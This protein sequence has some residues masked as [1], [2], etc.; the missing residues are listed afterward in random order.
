MECDDLY[1]WI[2]KRPYMQN[3]YQKKMNPRDIAG[4]EEEEGGRW[5]PEM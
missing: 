2:E 3:S 4:N 5:T 1:G